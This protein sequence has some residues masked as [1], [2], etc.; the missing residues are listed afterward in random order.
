MTTTAS[1]DPQ[2][3]TPVIVIASVGRPEILHDTLLSVGQQSVPFE[4]IVSVASMADVAPASLALPFVR[5][6]MGPK[7][8]SAQRNTGVQAIEHR[9]ECVC[10]LD[11]DVEVDRE[12]LREMLSCYRLRPEVAVLNGTDLA[13]FRFPQGVTRTQ[14]KELVA[15]SGQER[16][17]DG[18][19]AGAIL[20]LNT[21]YGC[22]MS[23]RGDL[24]GRVTFDERLV[25][26]G[27]LE[28]LDFALRCRPFGTIAR[29]VR[30]TMVHM[31][32][33]SGRVAQKRRGYS[34]IVN[35]FYIWSKQTGFA[36]HRALLGSMRRTWNNLRTALRMRDGSRVRG[37]VLGWWDVLR[38]RLRPERILAL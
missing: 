31:E 38:G 16:G 4:L 13:A 36:W 22:L 37:N 19:D 21:S 12:Y 11:D 7:G 20:P 15:A 6:V 35:P 14:A 27:F 23:F 25:L 34:D 8:S 5:V 1:G 26:Y 33:S 3:T 24:L 28:D 30:A 10:F 32:A 29:S 17:V 2:R 9:P 18:A